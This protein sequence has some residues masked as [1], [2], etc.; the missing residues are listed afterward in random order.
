M[1]AFGILT[2]VQEESEIGLL[3]VKRGFCSSDIT[4]LVRALKSLLL[5]KV[6]DRR[7]SP[8]PAFLLKSQNPDYLAGT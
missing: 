4:K 3:L 2:V 5:T 7:D 1:F 8:K 6:T